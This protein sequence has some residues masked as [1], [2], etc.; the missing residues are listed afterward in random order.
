MTKYGEQEEG[1]EFFTPREI[2]KLLVDPKEG[3]KICVYSSWSGG[4]DY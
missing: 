4:L 3:M 1:G 2:V